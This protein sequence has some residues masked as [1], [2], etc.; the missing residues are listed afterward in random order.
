MPGSRKL[1][2]TLL[3]ASFLNR[4]DVT[5]ARAEVIFRVLNFIIDYMLKFVKKK[6]RS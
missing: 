4:G 1:C 2:R 6:E 3:A 5:L